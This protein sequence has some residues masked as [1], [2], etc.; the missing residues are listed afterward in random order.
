VTAPSGKRVVLV[1][2][3]DKLSFEVANTLLETA[4]LRND[5]RIETA[6]VAE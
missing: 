1:L 3:P 6:D 2:K 5:A 4:H